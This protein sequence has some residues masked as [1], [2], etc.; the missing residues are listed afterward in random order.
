MKTLLFVWL[1]VALICFNGCAL[2]QA[3]SCDDLA[4]VVRDASLFI[5]NLAKSEKMGGSS[6]GVVKVLDGYINL[7]QAVP[8]N[9][10]RKGE[11]LNRLYA[12]R[13]KYEVAR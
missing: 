7:V 11:L 12:V 4:D 13:T 5:C 10:G 1:V 6:A 9:D 3:T 8:E 2:I